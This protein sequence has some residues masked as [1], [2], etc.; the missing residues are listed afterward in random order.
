[1]NNEQIHT[2]FVK[3]MVCHR[4]ILAVENEL[5]KLAITPK[6]VLLGEIKLTEKLSVEQSKKLNTA[7]QALGFEVIEDKKS[8]LV[9][10]I[11]KTI[12]DW[13]HYQNDQRKS[14]WSEILPKT[15]HHDYHYL[16]TLFS[17]VEKTTIEKYFIAQ[18][19][20]K[21]KEFLLYNEL[22]LSQIAHRLNYSSVSYLSN[23]FK[24][25]TGVS[26]SQFKQ[27]RTNQRKPLDEI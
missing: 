12:I 2:I 4:C 24:K 13:V 17:E 26:P 16:S 22:T 10:Q 1:M 3:N 19:I 14:N 18:K 11:K 20:E 8:F 27:S 15:L 7:L 23:Q 21:V 5:E 25:V 9:E 6:E